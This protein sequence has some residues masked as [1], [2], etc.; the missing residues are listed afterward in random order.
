MNQGT[1]LSRAV[2]LMS[3]GA[4][5]MCASSASASP[6]LNEAIQRT[7]PM[8]YRIQ[9]V[10]EIEVKHDR[11]KP[12]VSGGLGAPLILPFPKE[13]AYHKI[14]TPKPG[15]Y[16]IVLYLNEKVH[17]KKFEFIPMGSLETS[18]ARIDVPMELGKRLLFIVQQFETA[19]SSK[20]DEAVL[21]RVPW[22]D[23][24]PDEAEAALLPQMYIESTDKQVVNLMTEWTR[25][26]PRTVPP[27][28]LG[29][30]LARQVTRAFQPGEFG[31][32]AE[33]EGIHT[34][35][36]VTGA[37]KAV[38]TRLGTVH[39]E[40]CL[41]VAVCRAAGLPARP[42][43]GVNVRSRL[44][45]IISWA[46]FFIPGAGWVSVD[47]DRLHGS[48]GRIRDIDSAWP[49]LGTDDLLNER[50]P[51]AYHY[52]PPVGFAGEKPVDR[53]LLWSWAA[54]PDSFYVRQKMDID[55]DRAPRNP[56]R[57]P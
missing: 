51:L 26:E 47:F 9:L 46:E 5:V 8:R 10:G 3:C 41:F 43:I 37:V 1:T 15:E 33:R 22:P 40:V 25:G 39:D 56:S 23:V 20:V 4:L 42:V 31:V 2:K 11:L 35:I 17:E 48:P 32:W 45:E 29:K 54:L 50:L 24:W 6:P 28:L 30:E 12:E 27:F 44:R 34:G 49:G 7:D 36:R 19:Y 57:D 53:P 18:A 16:L 38:Q 55:I 14:D 13:G 52:Y 21:K